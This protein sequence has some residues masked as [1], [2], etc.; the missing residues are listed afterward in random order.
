MSSLRYGTKTPNLPNPTTTRQNTPM[1]HLTTFI[2]LTLAVLL[3]SVGT[4]WGADFNKGVAAYDSGDYAT[5]LREWRPLAEQGNADAQ[6][7]LGFMYDEGKGVLQDNVYAHMWW[8][9]AAASG[10]KDAST[11][12]DMIAEK[13][14]P[15]K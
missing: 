11:N 13:M 14:T 3:G 5:A 12:R 7:N 15:T 10:Y 6:F 9:I 2:C 4:S 1:R 8:N